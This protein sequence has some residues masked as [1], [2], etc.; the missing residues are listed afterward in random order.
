MCYPL[1]DYNFINGGLD[2]EG[3]PWS[4][5]LILNYLL[6]AGLLPI[7]VVIVHPSVCTGALRYREGIVFKLPMDTS[8]IT[9][10]GIRVPA[11]RG[12][13]GIQIIIV[14]QYRSGC[15]EKQG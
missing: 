1:F 10:L 9:L 3:I 7:T 5:F 13:G 12:R 8:L 15:G 6:S 11:S 14:L 2:R 4:R